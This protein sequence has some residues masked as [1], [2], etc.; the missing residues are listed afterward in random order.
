MALYLMNLNKFVLA[1][2]T[3]ASIDLTIYRR[4]Q[5]VGIITKHIELYKSIV[6]HCLSSFFC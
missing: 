4:F 6:F 2:L 5:L 1:L 3:F